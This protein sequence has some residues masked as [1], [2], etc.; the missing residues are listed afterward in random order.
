MRCLI[1]TKGSDA[2]WVK[3]FF[4]DVEP[5]LLKIVNKPVLE[6]YL[7]FAVLL[8]AKDV[9]IVSDTTI[10]GIEDWFKTGEKWGLN[11]SYA[12]ARPDDTLKQVY[13]KNYSFCKEDNLLIMQGFNFIDYDKNGMP[14]T[15][16][17]IFNE[18]SYSAESMLYLNKGTTINAVS[19]AEFPAD[20]TVRFNKID[21]VTEY[22]RLS[23][24][25]LK[26]RNQQYVLPG[27]SNEKDA[28]FG[29]NFIFP[30]SSQV[31]KP[32]M[33]GN[34]VRFQE[35][36]AVGPHAIIG[37]NVIVDEGTTIC[38]S[39]IY[40]NSY[41]GCEL[42]LE[43]KIVYKDH[44][45][46]GLTGDCVQITDKFLISAVDKGIILSYFDKITQL[47]IATLL[48]AIQAIP[49]LLIYPWIYMML[50]K[51]KRQS[52]YFFSKSLHAFFMDNPDKLNKTFVGKL[53]LRLSLD[54]FPLLMLVWQDKLLLVGNHVF[55]ATTAH[56]KLIKDLP[57]YQ[58]GVFSLVESI[59][60]KPDAVA[61]FFE[62]EYLD[63]RCWRSNLKIMINLLI[64]RL[65]YGNS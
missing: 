39:I 24:D 55:T 30:H 35:H 11:V 3:E 9:R 2:G 27:Y 49:W 29:T 36:T 44:L 54:K 42:E 14:D 5:Y 40:D 50:K 26:N 21:S 7:D 22:F 57:T 59:R 41:V 61:E 62:L 17:C 43:N 63:T 1:Y 20:C 13:L 4:P 32:I 37:D 31:E 10:K 65:I 64:K 33:I 51:S 25:I 23:L 52:E 19:V 60:K 12:L 46:A 34:N 8:K 58:P 6:Y 47:L 53:Y 16:S 45:I 48:I 18:G 15:E 28:F 38:D 56:R